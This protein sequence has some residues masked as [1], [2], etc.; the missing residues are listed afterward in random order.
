MLEVPGTNDITAIQLKGL[1][2]TISIYN[3]CTHSRNE[4]TLQNYIRNHTNL[5]L[6][7]ESH[8]MIWAG[9]FNRHHLLWD[10]DEDVHLFTQK[11]NRA[12]ERL[13]GLIATY[14]LAMALPKGIPTLQ[15]MV[16]K[17]YSRRDNVFN[18]MG[19]SDLITKCEVDPTLRPTSTDHF[20]IVTNVLLQIGRAHV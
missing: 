2:G 8:R 9:D 19:L 3:D 18:T 11:A 6:A 7:D 12:A 14:D 4:S 13:I 15:H 5:V 20:P 17:R 1:Y 10:N 16:T